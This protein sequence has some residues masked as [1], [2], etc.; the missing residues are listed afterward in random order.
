[1]ALLLPAQ[2]ITCFGAFDSCK[3]S[4]V[5]LLLCELTILKL[6]IWFAV[7]EESIINTEGGKIPILRIMDF[8]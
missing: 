8:F 3:N 7:Q 5:P 2:N 1:M 4:P 6:P